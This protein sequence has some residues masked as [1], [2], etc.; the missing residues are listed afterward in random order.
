ML[1]DLADESFVSLT[2]F[3]RTGEGVPTTVW[4]AA[5]PDGDGL[6]VMTIDGSGKVKRVRNDPRVTLRP[7][8]RLGNVDDDAATV[9]AT[10]RVGAFT[11]RIEQAFKDAY[12]A[13]Y[14]VV[15]GVERLTSDKRRVAL[16]LTA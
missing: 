16:H 15:R 12:G 2:T 1:R 3:R 7:C 9:E 13:E 4:V 6:V 14:A 8:G 10:A 5:D 11:E